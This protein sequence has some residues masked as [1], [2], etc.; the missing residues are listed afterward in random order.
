MGNI[1][2]LFEK[3]LRRISFQLSV[4]SYKW[5]VLLET[6]MQTKTFLKWW[7]YYKCAKFIFTCKLE[8][9]SGR[10]L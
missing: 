1:A 7:N 9:N 2:A 3:V 5:E 10:N 8:K 6:L 4:S